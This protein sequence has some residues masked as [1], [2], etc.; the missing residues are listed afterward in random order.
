MVCM[1]SLS[2]QT[3]KLNNSLN[4]SFRI[5]SWVSGGVFLLCLKGFS[6][7]VAMLFSGI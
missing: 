5:L 3:V 7:T 4:I 1:L 2:K 6:V